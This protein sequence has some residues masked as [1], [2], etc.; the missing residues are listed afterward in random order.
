MW[1]WKAGMKAV[2]LYGS[3]QMQLS[4]MG[5]S[6]PAKG[7]I[8]TVEATDDWYGNPSLFLA[9]FPGQEF[10]AENFRPLVS[11]TEEQ[12]IALFKRIAD[13]DPTE[14]REVERGW[15]YELATD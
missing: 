1:T 3:W 12:D 2:A 7:A 11:R 4:G 8:C 5:V 10:L 9:E 14:T 6:G 13:S 15:G